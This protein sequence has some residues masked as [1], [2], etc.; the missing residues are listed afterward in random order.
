MYVDQVINMLN[1][2]KPRILGVI[3]SARHEYN[4]LKGRNG[5]FSRKIKPPKSLTSLFSFCELP[6]S[7]NPSCFQGECFNLPLIVDD[8]VS[9]WPTEQHDNVIEVRERQCSEVWDVCLDE[10]RN[11]LDAIHTEVFIQLGGMKE[12]E[13][14]RLVDEQ[15][16][17]SVVR[18]YKGKLREILADKIAHS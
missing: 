8:Q 2:S 13:L 3:Y 10:V 9:T 6:F 18:T 1:N 17:F 14:Q 12:E 11:I 4:F 5:I 16:G 7:S 15:G